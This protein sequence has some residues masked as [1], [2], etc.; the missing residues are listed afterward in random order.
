MLFCHD[1]GL[2]TWPWPIGEKSLNKKILRFSLNHVLAWASDLNWPCLRHYLRFFVVF[3]GIIKGFSFIILFSCQHRLNYRLNRG[4]PSFSWFS[5]LT[6]SSSWLTYSFSCPS[7]TIL[8][9]FYNFSLFIVFV[10]SQFFFGSIFVNFGIKILVF[11]FSL[12]HF[13]FLLS[14]HF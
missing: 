8:C 2:L 7:L 5:R 9:F 13:M 1:L 12:N 11:L 6:Y 4:C 10:S 3:L 14:F